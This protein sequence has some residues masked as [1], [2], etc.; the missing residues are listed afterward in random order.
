MSFILE[1]NR[2]PGKQIVFK[3]WSILFKFK[4][5][6]LARAFDDARAKTGL[7]IQDI[8]ERMITYCLKESGYYK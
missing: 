2:N 5:E 3:P 6:R 4:N 7:T 1:P 8:L